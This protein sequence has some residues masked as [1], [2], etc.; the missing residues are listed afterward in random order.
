M[1]LS[2]S[3]SS[4]V[5]SQSGQRYW[6]LVPVPAAS[7]RRRNPAPQRG[8]VTSSFFINSP[9]NETGGIFNAG[10]AAELCSRSENYGASVNGHQYISP[11]Q[12][13]TPGAPGVTRMLGTDW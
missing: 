1:S 5:V 9:Q 6:P 7:S 2:P 13:R 11:A 8:H 4:S 3:N 10:R 12:T